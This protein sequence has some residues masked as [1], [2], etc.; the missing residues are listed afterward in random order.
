[1]DPTSKRFDD[2]SE[3]ERRNRY[4]RYLWFK[5]AERIKKNGMDEPLVRSD[6]EPVDMAKL[7]TLFRSN[8]SLYDKL[9]K[10][11]KVTSFPLG[12]GLTIERAWLTTPAVF[13]SFINSGEKMQFQYSQIIVTLEEFIEE[14]L[15]EF[16]SKDIDKLL[17]SV[18]QLNDEKDDYFDKIG[19]VVD[20]SGR[21]TSIVSSTGAVGIANQDR[22]VPPIKEI[23][24]KLYGQHNRLTELMD[25]YKSRQ[26]VIGRGADIPRKYT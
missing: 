19:L 13:S 20:P 26:Q 23:N 1:M 18:K 2:M 6:T 4:G 7:F 24:K 3:I 11:I 25:V 21:I 5:S 8:A 22:M 14:D 16:T 9:N 10:F 15:S 12:G 17:K